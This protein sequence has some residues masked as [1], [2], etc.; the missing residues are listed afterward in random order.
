MSD[1]SSVRVWTGVCVFGTFILE[2]PQGDDVV[3]FVECS[4]EDLSDTVFA[5]VLFA[6]WLS[7]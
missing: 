7:G 2:Q 5:L 3:L 4:N 6:T 1:K